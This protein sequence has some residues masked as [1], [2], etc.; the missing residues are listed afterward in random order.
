MSSLSRP[1]SGPDAKPFRRLLM[2]MAPYRRQFWFGFLCV[3]IA[4]MLSIDPW[5]TTIAL[6][7][8][9]VLS[10]FVRYFGAAIH[11]RF[12]KIQEQLSDISA[13]TQESLSG[14]RVVRAYRQEAFEIER[15][16]VANEEY[17]Q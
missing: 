5:L 10:L 8:L 2:A 6:I 16:R 3:V 11:H 7:P 1:P 14:V 4:L 15:F 12:E 9:P 13:V 17:L